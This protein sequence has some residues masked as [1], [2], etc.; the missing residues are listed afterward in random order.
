MFAGVVAT[1][2]VSKTI[3]GSRS[4]VEKAVQL[5]QCELHERIGE[6]GMGSVYRASHGVLERPTAIE[7]IPPDRSSETAISR[8]EHEVV[9]ASRLTH[10]L[11]DRRAVLERAK[12][13]RRRGAAIRRT[14]P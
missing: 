10:P 2:V 1:Y 4:A 13:L 3:C 12:V 14:R 6:G 9:A 11:I 5:G 8:F 7:V